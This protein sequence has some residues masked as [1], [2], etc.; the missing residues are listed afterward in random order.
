MPKA[1]E[2]L[3][4]W[5]KTLPN[6]I[7]LADDIYLEKVAAKFELTGSNI[8]NIVQYISLQLIAKGNNDFVLNTALLNEGIE[9]EMNKEGK[10][11]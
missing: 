7:Q 8:V 6:K 3:L 9:R 2:R 10:I 5:Q 4:L 11:Y 1:A